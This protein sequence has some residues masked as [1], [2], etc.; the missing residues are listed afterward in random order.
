MV[1]TEASNVYLENNR[2]M[3]G[4]VGCYIDIGVNPGGGKLVA[5]PV[6]VSTVPTLWPLHGVENATSRWLR[7]IGVT[8]FPCVNQA[9]VYL[10]LIMPG[11]GV[12]VKIAA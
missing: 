1:T 11:L 3:I 8:M 4:K 2:L 5:E 12:K 9:A 7:F 10:M 6:I